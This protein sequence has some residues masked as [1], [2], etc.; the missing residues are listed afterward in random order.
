VSVAITADHLTWLFDSELPDP[1]LVV[2]GGSA[3]VVAGPGSE[4]EGLVVASRA[5]LLAQLGGRPPQ[6]EALEQ[7]A[8]RLDTGVTGMGG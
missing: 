4:G 1:H 2:A 6:G 3:R 5:D 7:L 8:N